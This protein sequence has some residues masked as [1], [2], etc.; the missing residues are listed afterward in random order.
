MRATVGNVPFGHG[1]L[2]VSAGEWD[3][4]AAGS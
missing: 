3:P 2:R 4:V 1:D